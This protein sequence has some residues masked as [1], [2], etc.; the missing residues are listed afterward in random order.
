LSEHSDDLTKN[1]MVGPVLRPGEITEAVLE[2]LPEDN[3]G[4]HFEIS[5]G[6]GLTRIETENEC[7]IRR[8]TMSRILGRPFV[9]QELTI[10]LAT[11]AGRIDAASDHFRFFLERKL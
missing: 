8:D 6:I 11:F 3:P 5:D 2:A 9:M 7:I 4:K 10:V 1:N